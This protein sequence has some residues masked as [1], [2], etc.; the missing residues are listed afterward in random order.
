MKRSLEMMV[1][2]TLLCT[3]TA[4]QEESVKPGINA[5]FENPDVEHYVEIFEGESRSIFA[6][7]HEIVKAL[8]L[9]P[10]MAVGDIGAGTGFFSLLFSDVLGPQGEVYA[11]DIAKGFIDHIDELSREHNKSNI[12]GIVCDP[13]SVKLPVHSIDVAFICDVYHHFEYPFDSMKSIY[14][15]LKPGGSV[16]I[17]DF[18]RIEGYSSDWTLNHVRCSLGTVIDEVQA[19]GF[20]FAEKIDL[21]MEDQYVIRFVKRG[22]DGEE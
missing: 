13:H 5:G 1:V 21:G 8:G 2:A 18:R 9:K 7:R 4:A 10:G 11:V 22:E 17:V 14:K 12:K 3:L 16:L 6:K 20:Y 15:A 19:S